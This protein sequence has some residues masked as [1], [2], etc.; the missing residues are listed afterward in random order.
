MVT[1]PFGSVDLRLLLSHRY[2]V[3]CRLRSTHY[4][5]LI[6]RL[7]CCC[8]RSPGYA[9]G[10]LRL[11]L[12]LLPHTLQFAL[13]IFGCS[14]T[15]VIPGL[16]L[17][18]ILRMLRY[19]RLPVTFTDSVGYVYALFCHILVARVTA[20]RSAP[21]LRSDFVDYTPRLVTLIDYAPRSVDSLDCPVCC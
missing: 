6:L 5:R 10:F 12:Q 7:R 2:T 17:I 18:T 21:T 4:L 15:P 3:G 13:R 9:H 11:R 20:T 19:C 8:S 16:R 1:L 14:V